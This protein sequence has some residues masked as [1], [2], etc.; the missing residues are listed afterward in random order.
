MIREQ[1][2]GLFDGYVG[3]FKRWRLEAKAEVALQQHGPPSTAE[4]QEEGCQGSRVRQR[5]GGDRD[6]TPRE[7]ASGECASHLLRS[8]GP[9]QFGGTALRAEVGRTWGGPTRANPPRLVKDG[10]AVRVNAAGPPRGGAGTG[11]V[12][13]FS[14]SSLHTP[15]LI[16]DRHY[17][18]SLPCTSRS[19]FPSN[20][21]AAPDH[22]ARLPASPSSKMPVRAFGQNE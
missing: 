12:T 19:G 11:S 14:P 7:R 5:V 9:Q 13:G 4:G 20:R 16:P 22:F 21:A 1:A 17:R 2:R 8:M 10:S 15:G 18:T 6:L 3:W